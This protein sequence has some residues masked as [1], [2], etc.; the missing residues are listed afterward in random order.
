MAANPNEIDEAIEAIKI[1]PAKFYKFPPHLK[2]N[3][4]VVMEAVS[5]NG[6]LL[7]NVSPRLKHD[8]EVS[9]TAV[10]TSGT[11]AAYLLPEMTADKKIMMYAVA[12]WGENINYASPELKAGGLRDYILER[13]A[14]HEQRKDVKKLPMQLR[15]VST[16]PE[17]RPS[18][19]L[20]HQ[21]HAKAE[22][23]FNLIGDFVAGND[24]WEI[25]K[26]AATNMGIPIPAHLQGGKKRKTRRNKRK[27]RRH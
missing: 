15:N 19:T 9:L 21:P 5:R 10:N 20:L 17:S 25:V 1:D 23:M 14:S 27:S 8:K 3:K 12:K 4:R 2:D 26:R 22:R 18:S 11:S 7:A 13:I 16:A 6:T 24:D